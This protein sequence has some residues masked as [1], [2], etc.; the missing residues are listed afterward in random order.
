M[1][2]ATEIPIGQQNRI[3]LI[4][5]R[6][7]RG[8]SNGYK[9]TVDLLPLMPKQSLATLVPKEIK[10]LAITEKMRKFSP[11]NLLTD[12]QLSFLKI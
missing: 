4:F 7:F 1:Q 10:S 3:T 5:T 2:N 11:R 12:I 8:S 9:H 6:E